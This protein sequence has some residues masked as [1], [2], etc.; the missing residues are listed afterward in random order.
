MTNSYGPTGPWCWVYTQDDVVLNILWSY[1]IYFFCWANIFVISYK[2]YMLISYFNSRSEEIKFNQNKIEERKYIKKSKYIMYAF[3]IIL[4]ISKFPATINRCIVL[5]L[6][7][8]SPILYH[9]QASF[10]ACIGFFNSLVFI[11]IH[12]RFILKK[13]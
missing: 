7:I 8:N 4:I 3:P 5:I 10:S 9:F 1:I 12:R 13:K 6:D 2:F 11:Y